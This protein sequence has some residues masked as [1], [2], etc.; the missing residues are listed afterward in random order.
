MCVNGVCETQ[1]LGRNTGP[2]CSYGIK[3]RGPGSS[4]LGSLKFKTVRYGH[5]CCG[6]RIREWLRWRG[7]A[8]VVNSLVR[9]GALHQ[10]THNYLAIIKIW[11]WTTDGHLIGLLTVGRNNTDLIFK[12]K[13]T[14]RL[15]DSR[16]VCLGVRH[17]FGTLHEFFS[18]FLQ[19]FF[20]QLWVCWCGEPSPTRGRVCSFQ[21]LLGSPAESFSGLG[22]AGLMTIFYCLSTEYPSYTAR[23]WVLII[24]FLLN[25]KL[26]S[27]PHMKHITSP[28]QS[29]TW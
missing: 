5:E 16:P 18:F 22:P 28:L 3:L 13:V 17:P 27:V 21:L 12:V 19:L 14:L 2:P 7:P 24:D 29:S 26:Q 15:T 8:P 4:G 10:Q 9:V 23:H 25:Y 20:R 1:C 6:T 11:S